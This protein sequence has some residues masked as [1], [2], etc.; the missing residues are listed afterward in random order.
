MNLLLQLNGGFG[1]KNDK[2]E[3]V[4]CVLKNEIFAIGLL[5]VM[6]EERRNGF[7]DILIHKYNQIFIEKFNLD[8]IAFIVKDNSVS[9]AFFGKIG[10]KEVDYVTWIGVKN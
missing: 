9:R 10:F 4:A 2:H 1:I 3:L 5:F 6:E 8:P 7:A